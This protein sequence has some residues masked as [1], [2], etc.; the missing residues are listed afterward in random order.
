MALGA[1]VAIGKEGMAPDVEVSKLVVDEEIDWNR[2]VSLLTSFD[3]ETAQKL[4]EGLT[5]LEELA[6]DLVKSDVPVPEIVK[7]R[8]I[9]AS[10][11]SSYETTGHLHSNAS[12]ESLSY[13]KAAALRWILE[14][15]DEKSKTASPRVKSAQSARLF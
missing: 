7:E 11:I 6:A 14:L 8:V 9:M 10:M 15:E 2:R 12:G 4:Y 5:A 13:L 3:S 1:L